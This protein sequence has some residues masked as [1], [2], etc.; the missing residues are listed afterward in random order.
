MAV[1][2]GQGS[3][4]CLQQWTH[5]L[6]PRSHVGEVHSTGSFT[7]LRAAKIGEAFYLIKDKARSFQAEQSS[8]RRQEFA[9]A[10]NHIAC[11][12]ARA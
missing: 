9:K 8:Q 12:G 3:L 7:K 5:W 10:S 6:M 1:L 2:R 11:L 4:K